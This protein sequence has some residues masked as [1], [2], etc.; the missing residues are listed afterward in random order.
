MKNSKALFLLSFIILLLFNVSCSENTTLKEKKFPYKFVE[1]KVE[2]DG[3]FQNKMD[4]YVYDG[5]I[6]LIL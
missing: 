6:I 3:N 5:E 4:L 2:K 1:T